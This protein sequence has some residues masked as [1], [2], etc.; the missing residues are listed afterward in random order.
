MTTA[1]VNGEAVA[2]TLAQGAGEQFSIVVPTGAENLVITLSGLT[3]DLDLCVKFGVEASLTIHDATSEEGGTATETVA[4]PTPSAGVY[5]IFAYGYAAGSGLVTASFVDTGSVPALI[6]V[7][8][9]RAPSMP[10]AFVPT[11]QLV[12]AIRMNPEVVSD[13]IPTISLAGYLP[14]PATMWALTADNLPAAQTI[15]ALTL[16]G[17]ADGLADIT[18]PMASFQ[19]RLNEGGIHYL[20][21]VV[22]NS[23]RWADAIAAR[24]NGQWVVRKGYRFQNGTASLSEIVRVGF[25]SFSWSRG[26]AGDAAI[27]Y[28]NAT[29]PV[30]A[31]K[32]VTM[33]GIQYE[34]LDTTGKRRIRC[35][36]SMFLAPGDWCIWSGGAMQT[37]EIVHY[38]G[39]S[40]AFM[41]VVE[42]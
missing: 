20:S 18:I 36:V 29:V 10:F 17:G 38:V 34:A 33:T 25:T 9:V 6:G 37:G 13:V 2:V 19:T 16:T 1:L 11:V 41:E 4:F 3:N 15:Y 28:G 42:S 23:R 40:M 7:G 5:Y 12:G 31:A 26:S 32:S 14:R 39:D 35:D 24:S 27:I 30:L 21:A 22:P 8:A